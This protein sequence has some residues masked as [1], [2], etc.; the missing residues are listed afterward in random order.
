M[1]IN[2][3][4]GLLQEARFIPSP[5]FGVRPNDCRIDMVVIHNIS[6]P[7][8][9][10]G[11]SYIDDF[12]CNRLDKTLHPYFEGIIHLK[13]SS[14]CLIRRHGQITQY[15][16]FTQRAWHAGISFFQGRADCN[17]FSIGIELEGADDIPYTNEQYVALVELIK[18]LRSTYKDISLDRIVGH[19]TIAPDRKTDPGPAFDWSLLRRRLEESGP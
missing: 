16:P 8:R 5:N 19:D 15:V 2:P 3:L 13:V 11:G 7:P 10:F 14:H 17:D 6:L 9:E 4:T 1:N 18:T 12:F